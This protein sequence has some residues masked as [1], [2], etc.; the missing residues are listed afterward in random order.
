MIWIF[1]TTLKKTNM[2]ISVGH[3]PDS[4]DAFMFYGMFTDKVPSPDFTVKSGDG[5]LSVNIP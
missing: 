5:T 3:T 2:E 4:D 1:I